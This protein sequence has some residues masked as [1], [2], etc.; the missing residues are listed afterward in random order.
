MNLGRHLAE[1][2]AGWLQYEFHCRR[3]WLFCER[4]LT[5]PV[6]QVLGSEMDGRVM[7]EVDH[8]LLSKVKTGSGKRP[9]I[10]FAVINPGDYPN[11][12]IAVET[13]W[14]GKTV[15]RIADLLWDLVRIELIV[16][17]SHC[18]GFFL[19]A[20]QNKRLLSLFNSRTFLSKSSRRTVRPILKV[21]SRRSMGLRLDNPP[22]ERVKEVRELFR[23]YPNVL[24]PSRIRS[25]HPF[26]SP[27]EC[28]S[29]QYQVFVWEITP[30]TRRT[31]FFPRDH[32]L[33]K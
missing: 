6:V 14:I 20:G 16:S 24:M 22:R 15:P 31:P 8:P 29:N 33:Y 26:I 11:I 28:N 17:N 5:Y 10:D 9:K 13:K 7:C 1:G 19:I 32:K 27:I 12:K 30:T 23:K 3:Q 2:V 25:G 4:Y 21:D 18:R